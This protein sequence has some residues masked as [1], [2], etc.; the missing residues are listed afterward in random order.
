[1]PGSVPQTL[2]SF[3]P[4][5]S[6]ASIFRFTVTGP[7]V[8]SAFSASASRV[9]IEKVGTFGAVANVCVMLPGMLTLTTT[10]AA[11]F[12]TARCIAPFERAV[13]W[14]AL[15]RGSLC[16]NTSLPFTSRPAKS[17]SVP[18][19]AQTISRV[20]PAGGVLNVSSA[21]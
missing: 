20:T 2:L 10:A 3:S 1:M 15:G 13:P 11:P 18:S 16:R 6:S 9:P 21:G 4:D 12:C 8:I 7:L 5:R 17:S 19:P 14:K